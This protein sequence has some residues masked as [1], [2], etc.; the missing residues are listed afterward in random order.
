[1]ALLRQRVGGELLRLRIVG[2]GP[3]RRELE[4]RAAPLGNAV[5][6]VGAVPHDDVQQQLQLIDI[7]VAASRKESFGVA[8]IEASACGLPVVVSDADGLSEVVDDGVTGLV[9]RGASP[10]ALANAIE[11][12]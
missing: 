6:F 9:V 10:L 4:S 5:Q 7:Y 1:F 12:L 8:V 2:D 3:D 11:L